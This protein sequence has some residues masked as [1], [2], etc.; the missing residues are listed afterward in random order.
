MKIYSMTATFGKLEHQTLTLTPGL[1]IIHAPNEWG[2][3]TWCA[4]LAAML[5]G[6]DTR[7][8]STKTALADKE[9]YAPWSGSPMAGRMDICWQ[10]R[11]ITIQRRS[12]GRIPLGDFQAWETASG[13]PV[14]ELTAANCGTMLLGV[15][16]SVFLRSG[17]IRLNDMPVTQD[18]A[19]RHRLNALVTT[20]DESGTAEQLGKGLRELKNR[21]RYNRTGLLPQ[22]EGELAALEEKLRELDDLQT[23]QDLGRKR[24]EEL[25]EWKIRLE[26]HRT[27]LVYA[28]YREEAGQ[29]AQVKR[30]LEEAERKLSRMEAQCAALPSRERTEQVLGRIRQLQEQENNLQLELRL[31]CPPGDPVQAPEP[32]ADR[33]AA[34]AADIARN[35]AGQYHTW[36]NRGRLLI[37]L[38]VLMIALG[39]TLTARYRLPGLCCAGAGC[40]VLAA[41]AVLRLVSIRKA[42]KLQS[43]YGSEDTQQWIRMG[44]EYADAAARQNR[45]TAE[46]LA[47]RKEIEQRTQILA[48]RIR[49]NT[50]GEGLEA[51]RRDWESTLERWN[52]RDGAFRDVQQLRNHYRT[53]CAMVKPASP[54]EMPDDMDYSEQDTARLLSDCFAQRHTLERKLGQLQ[55]KT[56]ALGNRAVLEKRQED[57]LTQIHKLKQTYNALT[58]AQE[59]LAEAAAELQRRFAPRIS[60]RAQALMSQLTGGRYD[61]VALEKDLSLRAGAKQEDTLREALWRSDGTVDQLYLALRIAVAEELIPHGPLI[62]DDAL[63]RFDDERLAL[64]LG[65]LREE[66]G[67]KQVLLFTCQRRELDMV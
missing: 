21:I 11:D 61:R 56:E 17:F 29:A 12:K 51:C 8:K 6:L 9:R 48:D 59:T 14:P 46:Y 47:K 2:K 52:E 26:N 32:F 54:P 28:S 3:S 42:G 22:A 39:G 60:R 10:G 35:D 20:G 27:A 49:D 30:R 1:N 40:V 44:E 57:L 58:V 67:Q 33:D 62:L 55:G 13:L 31:L 45:E 18:E 15:E 23:Q 38:A 65:I 66:A 4:F 5:Y 50:N 36:K 53:L 64:A 34:R 63:V 24:L 19:L 7:A 16:R 41:A 43:L 37:L 25:E